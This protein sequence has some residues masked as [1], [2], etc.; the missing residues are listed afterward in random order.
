ME[1]YPDRHVKKLGGEVPFGCHNW[2]KL[3]ADFY[4]ELFAQFG[5]DLRPFRAQ[6]KTDDYEVQCPIHLT[7]VGAREVSPP[8][9]PDKKLCLNSRH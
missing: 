2:T 3:S 5:Y 9:S 7:K 1:W 8:I 6:M 4:V